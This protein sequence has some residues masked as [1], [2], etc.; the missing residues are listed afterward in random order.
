MGGGSDASFLCGACGGLVLE[1]RR[2]AHMEYWCTGLPEECPPAGGAEDADGAEGGSRI[3]TDLRRLLSPQW[4]ETVSPVLS[5]APQVPLQMEQEREEVE[6]DRHNDFATG[7]QL[8]WSEV[9]LAELLAFRRP[10]GEAPGAALGLGCGAAPVSAYV[11]AALGWEVLCT[12]LP[13]VLPAMRKNASANAQALEQLHAAL[14]PGCPKGRLDFLPLPFGESA[15]EAEAWLE[16]RGGAML[17]FCSDCIWQDC[18]HRALARTLAAT[19][20]APGSEAWIAYQLRQQHERRF[21]PVLEH[22]GLRS[23]P[24]DATEAVHRTRFP[25]Q[26]EGRSD[27]AEHFLVQRVWRP[28][29]SAE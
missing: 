27:A 13:E 1:S 22:Y 12:D 2:A 28:A 10:G 11:A 25:K 8:W 15:P 7:G 14:E 19:L 6:V 26:F 3:P 5:F 21:F 9:V 4:A 29:A 17:V 20:R 24:L 23:E 16:A 18:R